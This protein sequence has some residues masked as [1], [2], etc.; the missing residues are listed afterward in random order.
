MICVL[1]AGTT[2]Q[3]CVPK[4]DTTHVEVCCLLEQQKRTK[5]FVEIGLDAE[6]YYSIKTSEKKTGERKWENLL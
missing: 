1:Y 6:E 2:Y 5:D 4:K 3:I